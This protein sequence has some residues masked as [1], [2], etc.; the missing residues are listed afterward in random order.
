MLSGEHPGYQF[1]SDNVDMKTNVRHQTTANMGQDVH[2]FQI[3]AYKLRVTGDHLAGQSGE[4][5]KDVNFSQFLPSPDDKEKLLENFSY[6][7]ARVWLEFLPELH[8]LGLL[9]PKTIVHRHIKDLQ[10]KTER[11]IM[12]YFT[13]WVLPVCQNIPA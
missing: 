9:L 11:V 4:N 1:V 8:P 2:M 7:V 3:C 13:H 10:K 5:F 12:Y 6:H